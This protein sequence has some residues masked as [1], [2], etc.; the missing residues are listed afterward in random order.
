MAISKATDL[1]KV[2]SKNVN[3]VAN[4]SKNIADSTIDHAAQLMQT[5][6]HKTSEV[7]VNAKEK[8]EDLYSGIL[9]YVKNNPLKSISAVALVGLLAGLLSR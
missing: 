6:Q 8:T 4:E 5:V 7:A 9:G 1:K 3:D 2:I